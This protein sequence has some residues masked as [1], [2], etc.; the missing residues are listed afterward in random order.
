MVVNQNVD[1][2][3]LKNALALMKNLRPSKRPRKTTLMVTIISSLGL[4][5]YGFRNSSLG[6][7]ETT[8]HR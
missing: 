3:A 8:F 6:A 7:T 1:R 4:A 5:G 2:V